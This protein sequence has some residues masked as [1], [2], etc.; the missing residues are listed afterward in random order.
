MTLYK[1][2]NFLLTKSQKK[3]LLFLFVLLIISIFFELMG[4]GIMLPAFTLLLNPSKHHDSI[5]IQKITHF[6]GNPSQIKLVVIGML[7][8]VFIYFIKGVFLL[9]TSWKQSNFIS[10]LSYGI[11]SKLFHGYIN[12]PY[13]FFLKRNSSELLRNIQMEVHQFQSIILAIVIFLS[14]FSVIASILIFLLIIQPIGAISIGLFLSI[15]I[16]IFHQFSKKRLLDW[17]AQRQIYDS[18]IALNLMQ[19]FGAI[20]DIKILGRQH[21]FLDDFDINNNARSKIN[22]KQLTLQ[23]IP[24]LYL[25]FIAIVGLSGLV[26]LLIY[27][28]NSV[29]VVLPIIGVFAAAAFRLIPSAN[30]I[31]GSIQNIRYAI[32][33]VSLLYEELNNFSD[34]EISKKQI[35]NFNFKEIIISDLNFIYQD[36]DHNALNY[37]NL[38]IKK[39]ETV[40]FIGPSGSGKSTL[41]DILLGL[42]TPT[43][44]CIKI[45][46]H[47]INSNLISWQSQIGYV[48]QS[49]YLIDDTLRN[50]IA[51]GIPPHLIDE[52]SINNA[53]KSAHLS[54]F[55]LS[56]SEGLNTKVGERGVRLSGGQRQRIG[57]ARS[58]YH[59][60]SILVLDEAT[61]SLDNETESDIMKSINAMHGTRTIIIVAHRLST[62]SQCDKIFKMKS[63]TILKSGSPNEILNL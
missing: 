29:D 50:N 54:D 52:N 42:L 8:I 28:G 48:P 36:K 39:G 2:I 5:L 25:E 55:V 21:Y 57:I 61:S 35:A 4:I 49:I 63:G 6:L 12:Q 60:P 19:S 22:S 3:Q 33:V 16:L 56:L 43:S 41:I 24:R 47:N 10:Q 26:L 18:K 62:V 53:I 30:R 32:P 23:N 45:D 17:G 13:N 11:G 37:I 59:N 40:G 15:F 58:L 7:S 1:K 20:K 51:L 9:Y 27:F 46:D 14:E 34:F 38:S 44:G 31:M